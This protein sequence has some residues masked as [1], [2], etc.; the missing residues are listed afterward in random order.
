[1]HPKMLHNL[2]PNALKLLQDLFNS[3]LEQ[4]TWIWNEAEVIFLK[5]SGKD[6]YA[7][8]GSYRP[9]SITS[10]IGKTFEKILAARICKFLENQGILDP[11]QE[12]FTPKRSTNRYLNR[13]IFD[14]KND[15]REHTVISLFIDLEKAFDSI[16]KK[17]LIV[18][19]S[20]LNVKGNVLKLIDNFLTTRKVKLNVN[21]EVGPTR[22]C[23]EYGLPQGSALSPILFK[24]YLLDIFENLDSREDISCFKF[25]DDGSVKIKNKSSAMCVETL[26]TACNTLNAWTKKW[27]LNINCQPNKTEYICF[28]T[29][30]GNSQDVPTSVKLGN[31]NIKRVTQ[32]KVLGVTIDEDLSFMSH[33]KSVLGKMQGKWARICTYTNKHWGFNQ[34]VI[35]QIT[36]TFFLTSLHYCGINWIN[37]KNLNG[38]EQ[39]WYKIVKSA[40]GATFNIRKS[41]AEAILGLPP[42]S[43]QNE[44]NKIKY[45]LKLN[46]KPEKEDRVRHFIKSCYENSTPKEV[47]SEL[48]TSIKSVNKF[49]TWKLENYSLDFNDTDKTIIQLKLFEDYLKLSTKSCSYTKTM[50]T[51]YT[52]LIWRQRIQ[53]EFS[54]E[55]YDHAPIPSCTKLPV[56]AKVTREEEVLLMSMFYPNNLLNNNVYQLTYKIESPLCYKCKEKEESAYHVILECS[57]QSNEAYRLVESLS[58]DNIVHQDFISL[59]NASRNT[60]FIQI[61]LD[62]LAE[63]EHRHHID[64]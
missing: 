9:I 15:L 30:D 14:I 58:K 59:L 56:P 2:G 33:S 7:V 3:C 60:K 10:Y 13:L 37:E 52:E 23:K 45:F 20:K 8:P 39:M 64:L 44:V 53:N 38:I 5:K 61:C 16:W 29:P 54:I 11:D 46:I 63:R 41:I 18:K 17:G 43:I 57:D 42:I 26:Q 35:T 21:E 28:G 19:L 22:D 6:S 25:A 51:K 48:R 4:G 49:L 47:V 55:G 36:Q 27:R 50:M 1:M 12:G 40:V 34:K 24:I 32:S 31:S 62:I